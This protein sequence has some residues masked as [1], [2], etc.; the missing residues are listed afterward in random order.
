MDDKKLQRLEKILEIANSDVLTPDDMSDV[1]EAIVK[2]LKEYRIYL[3][4]STDEKC[5][6]IAHDVN[7]T[8]LKMESDMNLSKRE[9]MGKM[10][11]HMKEMKTEM[12]RIE[13]VIPDMPDM[14]DFSLIEKR[15]KAIEEKP[16]KEETGETIVDKINAL[17]IE[18][19]KQIDAKHI[20]GLEKYGGKDRVIYTGGGG[21]GGGRIV[22]EYDLSASLDGSTKTF[23]LPA[24]WRVISVHLS[25]FPNILRPTVDY[26]TSNPSITFT[27]EVNASTSLQNGQT[28]IVI[29]SEP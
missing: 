3:E 11:D 14:P 7:S 8:C 26:T 27:D 15:I 22:R 21:S 20:K 1:F 9:M 2:L 28:A 17:E 25:S 16:V 6:E 13:S 24:F 5:K 10:H 12:K 19:D 29:Y 23:T 18:P 4:K